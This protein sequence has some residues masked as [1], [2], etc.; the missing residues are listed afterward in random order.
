[1]N[2]SDIGNLVAKAAPLVGTALLGPAGGAI[3]AGLASLFGTDADPEKI[4]QAINADPEAMIKIRQYELANEKHLNE[5]IIKAGTAEITAVNATMQTEAKSDH[6][7]VSGWRPFWGFSSATAWAFLAITFGIAVLRGDGV[8][9]AISAF[10]SIPRSFW[11]IPLSVLGV[12][13]WHRGMEKRARA[14]GGSAQNLAKTNL[15]TGL[16]K[17]IKD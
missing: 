1:M 3:G 7:W 2:W 4:A 16:I 10:S 13:S 11:L 9:I 12:A 14:E 5:L 8:G 15:V 6:W 17:K